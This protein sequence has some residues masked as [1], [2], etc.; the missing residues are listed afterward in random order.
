MIYISF[1]EEEINQ[2]NYQRYH[3]PH[4]LVQKRMEVLYLKSQNLSHQEICRLCRISRPT[5]SFYLK[6]YLDGGIESLKIL[7]YKGQSSLLNQHQKTIEEY[8]R[9]NPPRNCAEASAIIQRLTGVERSPT[10]VREFLKRI[11]MKTRKIGHLPGKAAN[12]EKIQEQEE[13]RAKK[14]EPLLSEAK[15]GKR[16]VYFVDAAHFVHRA[17]LGFIWCFQ[18]IFIPSPSGRKRFNVLGAINAVTNQIITVTNESYI[19]SE[20]VCE[21][22]DKLAALSLTIP[23][24]LILDN[25]RYQKCHKVRDHAKQLGIELI[26]LPSY[27]P[28]LNLIER[29]WKFIRN[30][31]LY[32]KYY[33][34]FDDFKKAI[35]NCLHA[36]NTNTKKKEK[37]AKLL[38]W[39]FQSFR[40]VKFLPV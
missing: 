5:L 23:I 19:N 1:S 24:T 39:N 33:E 35:N 9:E 6:I 3:H 28:H 37:L 22:L 17:Y 15:E 30:E 10:Q 4:P 7:A 20:S 32:S 8:C 26:Y 14:L 36:T 34:T 12:P 21:L 13:F 38:T 27:S 31:C 25:A 11:G 29:L 2:L 16:A 18:R 40:K